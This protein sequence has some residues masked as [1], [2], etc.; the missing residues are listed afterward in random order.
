M[1]QNR[2]V[3]WLVTIASQFFGAAL[4][5]GLHAAETSQSVGNAEQI[6]FFERHVRPLLIEHCYK[7]HSAKIK[8]PKGGLRL[9]GRTLMTKGGD[10]GTA[11]V[12]GK[13]DESLFIESV[14]YESLEMP[15]TGKVSDDQLATLVRWVEMGAPWPDDETPQLA[16]DGDPYD[17]PAVRASHW[18]WQPIRRPALPAVKSQVWPQQPVD[19]FVLARLEADGRTVARPADKRTLIRR[20]YIDLTGLPPSP[21]AVEAFVIAADPAAFT[22][23]IDQLL[24]SVHY[25]ERWGRHWLDV[26]RYSDGLGGF[27]DNSRMPHAFRFRDWVVRCFNGDLPY[28]KFVT[29]QIAGDLLS[30]DE[31]FY[32]SGFFAIG[33][34]YRSDGG[35]PDSIAPAKSETLDDRVDTLSRAF[36]GLTVACARCHE[37]KFDPIP[38]QD[39]YSLA[40]VFNNTRNAER[41]LVAQPIV[42][43]YNQAQ[44]QISDHNNRLKNREKELKRD[45]RKPTAEQEPDVLSSNTKRANVLR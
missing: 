1:L 7:C 24:G 11:L 12:P 3:F 20:A 40:G 27:L 22:R 31:S 16:R 14:R 26:A 13:P 36:F 9:D 8:K 6:E 19:R 23:V 41:P 43:Q 45:G 10:S 2:L 33:P 25:G 21:E 4:S 5:A 37:H 32:G 35:D 42:D 39:Y 30:E 15:P 34:T 29:H 44:E 17:W 28:D 18:A 38:T